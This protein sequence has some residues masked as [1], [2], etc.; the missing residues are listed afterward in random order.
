MSVLNS[1]LGEERQVF[2]NGIIVVSLVTHITEAT[3]N[4]GNVSVDSGAL[5]IVSDDVTMIASRACWG[6]SLMSARIA[7]RGTKCRI[8]GPTNRDTLHS[9][10]MPFWGI[11]YAD[12]E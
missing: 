5:L 2:I 3:E 9:L 8:V 4:N 11:C 12:L 7:T 6:K 1:V 10:G